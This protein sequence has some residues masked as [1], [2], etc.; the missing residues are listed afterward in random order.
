M[1]NKEEELGLLEILKSNFPPLNGRGLVISI[2]QFLSTNVDLKN[3]MCEG[4]A[5]KE[6]ATH[7]ISEKIPYIVLDESEGYKCIFFKGNHLRVH[8]DVSNS[9]IV[10]LIEEN[11]L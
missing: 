7:Y 1:L 3:F 2:N 8:Y 9:K 11:Q 6:I 10:G 4:T 5:I